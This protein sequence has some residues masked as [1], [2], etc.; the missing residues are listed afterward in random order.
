MSGVR[1]AGAAHRAG[2]AVGWAA[3]EPRAGVLRGAGQCRHLPSL[4]AAEH[5]GQPVSEKQLFLQIAG[6]GDRLAP[7]PVAAGVSRWHM[8]R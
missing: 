7:G 6:A 5:W 8:S 4:V 2:P 1:A 3:A